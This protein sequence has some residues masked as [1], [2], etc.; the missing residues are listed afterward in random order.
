LTL[1][2]SNGAGEGFAFDMREPSKPVVSVPFIGID[3][4]EITPIATTFDGFLVNLGDQ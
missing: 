2:G 3:L 4:K 1:F